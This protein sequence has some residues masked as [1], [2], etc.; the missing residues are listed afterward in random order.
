MRNLRLFFVI[1]QFIMLAGCQ[2]YYQP[3]N[4]SYGGYNVIAGDSTSQGIQL[5]VR[6]YADSVKLVM[7]DPIGT[8]NMNLE[9]RLPEGTL[10]NFLADAY[11]EMA[12][13]KWNKNAAIA[14]M[15]HGGIRT[16][17]IS[18]GVI[19]RSTVY[20]V[21]P[22]DNEMILLEVPGTVLKEFLD[23]VAGDGG[24]GVAGMSF[25]IKNKKAEN[26]LIGGQPLDPAKKYLMVNSDY[27]VNGGGGFNG[28]KD[29]SRTRTGYLLRDAILE[30][31]ATFTKKNL[32]VQINTDKR[33][34]SEK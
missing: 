15:N 27:V 6:P 30:Y 14:Y 1:V 5:L 34:S 19:K 26:I 2:R 24:G 33:I 7:S 16:N 8:L 11:L 12:R 28:L 4:L 3:Q 13:I 29:L 23:V 31:V 20:E 17:T 32:P 9:K 10:G 22:F 18:A 21:M 25:I